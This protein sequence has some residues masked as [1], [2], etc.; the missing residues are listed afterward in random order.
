MADETPLLKQ[1]LRAT[2]LMLVPVA[3]F[4]G[5]VSAAALA[6]APAS[7]HSGSAAVVEGDRPAPPV[8]G[9]KPP[10]RGARASVKIAPS[11]L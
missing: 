5:V 6:I 11:K 10:S 1:T 3:L 8:V 4:L 9:E 2:A 7:P